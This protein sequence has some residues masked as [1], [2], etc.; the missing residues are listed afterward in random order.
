MTG[1][2]DTS[3][4]KGAERCTCFA[5]RKLARRLTQL[6]DAELAAAGMTVTQFGILAQLRTGEGSS[7]SA[8]A[9]ALGMERSTLSRTLAPLIEAGW[10]AP[11]EGPDAR[12]TVLL[13][14]PA[15]R[16]AWKAAV[17][18]WA[19]AQAKVEAALG[20]QA[21]QSFTALARDVHRTLADP[22]EG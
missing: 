3:L 13:A 14:T 9:R 6:Y 19:A 12:R 5:V 7:I 2:A 11:A 17:P 1:T 8:L 4:P 10:V 21:A 18:H 15:G 20:E 22:S 16:A